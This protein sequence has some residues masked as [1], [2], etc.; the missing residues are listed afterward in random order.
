MKTLRVATFNIRHGLGVDGRLSL[1]RTARVILA[2]G[3]PV[4]AV[5]EIDRF[6]TRSGLIDQAQVLGTLTGMHVSFHPT[7]S[8][9]DSEYG[10]ALLSKSRLET[11]FVRLP[12]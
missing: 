3:A 4:V 11:H 2:T 7:F 8:R 12:R 10:I 1:D 5:Q 6:W 9:G